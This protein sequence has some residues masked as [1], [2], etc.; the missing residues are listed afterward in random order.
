VWILQAEEHVEA[1]A[2][3]L[4]S[5]RGAISDFDTAKLTFE[6]PLKARIKELERELTDER[7]KQVRAGPALNRASQG[8]SRGKLEH[9][10]HRSE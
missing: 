5:M 9:D 2:V 8:G 10:D 6:A 4:H 1:L 7:L 3:E